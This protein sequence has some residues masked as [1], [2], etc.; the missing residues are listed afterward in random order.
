M[1]TCGVKHTIFKRYQ[2]HLVIIKNVKF[3]LLVSFIAMELFRID[4]TFEMR[5]VLSGIRLFNDTFLNVRH[6]IYI[7]RKGRGREQDS[8]ETERANV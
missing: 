3:Y 4:V 7:K 2:Q 6:H 8:G 1:S 5:T